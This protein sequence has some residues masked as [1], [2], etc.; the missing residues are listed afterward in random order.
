M[1]IKRVLLR[2]N[3]GSKK[4]LCSPQESRCVGGRG[5]GSRQLSTTVLVYVGCGTKRADA[6]PVHAKQHEHFLHTQ[7]ARLDAQKLAHHGDD[8][9]DM[10]SS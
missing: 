10:D 8:D 4:Q 2:A 3:F 1:Y 6:I 5:R 7:H 9:V